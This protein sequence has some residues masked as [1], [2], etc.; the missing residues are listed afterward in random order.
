MHTAKKFSDDVIHM[1][2][3]QQTVKAGFDMVFC[4]FATHNRRTTSAQK[5]GVLM[6]CF[7]RNFCSIAPPY[8][9][10]PLSNAALTKSQKPFAQ[11]LRL[12]FCVLQNLSMKLLFL[13]AGTCKLQVPLLVARPLR[14]CLLVLMKASLLQCLYW[15]YS[16]KA[17]TS[18]TNKECACYLV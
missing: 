15:H 3:R 17:N 2:S 1:V 9:F 13:S 6:L 16:Y 18:T 14:R 12:R 8:S 4:F 11:T 5:K 10:C 7:Y